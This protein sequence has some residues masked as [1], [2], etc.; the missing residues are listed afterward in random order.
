MVPFHEHVRILH[1]SARARLEAYS[2]LFRFTNEEDIDTKDFAEKTGMSI[3]SVNSMIRHAK[4]NAKLYEEMV[5]IGYSDTTFPAWWYSPARDGTEVQEVEQPRTE[6]QEDEETVGKRTPAKA[7]E[8][9]APTPPDQP[10]PIGARSTRPP[11]PVPA[12]AS[13]AMPTPAPASASSGFSDLE[14]CPFFVTRG[15]P[16][17]LTVSGCERRSRQMAGSSRARPYPLE[18]SFHETL[19]VYGC[20]RTVCSTYCPASTVVFEGLGQSRFP[21]Q[22]AR[23]REFFSPRGSYLSLH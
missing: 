7:G 23:V 14:I 13:D 12:S 11:V 1:L 22:R 2:R 21:S 17:L 6:V 19:I 3:N 8:E 4:Q 20:A 10:R 9:Y 15:S 16:R 18:G 5:A